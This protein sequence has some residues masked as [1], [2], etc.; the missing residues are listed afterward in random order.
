MKN[1]TF[2]SRGTDLATPKN[3]DVVRKS[4]HMAKL[5]V[6]AMTDKISGRYYNVRMK[7]CNATNLLYSVLLLNRKISSLALTVFFTFG[8]QLLTF[9]TL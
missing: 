5:F 2:T 8:T 1:R 6:N 7:H 9:F 4:E 3:R